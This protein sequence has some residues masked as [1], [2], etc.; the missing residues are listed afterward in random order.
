MKFPLDDAIFNYCRRHGVAVFCGAVILLGI[1]MHLTVRDDVPYP[2]FA[3]FYALPRPLLL[4]M[5]VTGM[6]AGRTRV[7]RWSFAAIALALGAWVALC[8]VSWNGPA[9]QALAG[10][11]VVFWNVGHNLVE[12][13]VA[14]DEMLATSPLVVGLVE[15][16]TLTPEWLAAWQARHTDYTFVVPHQGMLLAVRGSVLGQAYHRLPHNSHVAWVETRIEGRRVRV[17]LVDLVANPLISRGDTLR[18]LTERLAAWDDRP[19]VVM[20]DFN[21]PVESVWMMPIRRQFREAFLTA[22]TG[23][24]PTWPWPLPVLKLDQIWINR[25]VD[26]RHAGQ[27]GTWRSDHRVQWARLAILAP[28]SE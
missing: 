23:Y 18:R 4:S 17:A 15:T 12:D 7:M 19:L 1:G 22:G 3:L 8:D 13:S 6:L 20:G 24:I 28:P 14:V 11:Q 5:S 21:T 26:V 10:E 27:T 25:L 9:N 16:G 2:L